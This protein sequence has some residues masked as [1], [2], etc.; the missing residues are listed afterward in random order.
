MRAFT[1]VP[2]GPLQIFL[3]SDDRWLLA[4][5]DEQTLCLCNAHN[6]Q[7]AA[8]F[9]ADGG[10]LDGAVSSDGRWKLVGEDA[11]TVQ[12]WD[13]TRRRKVRTFRQIAWDSARQLSARDGTWEVLPAKDYSIVIRDLV[14]EQVRQV[15]WGHTDKVNAVCASADGEWILSGGSDRTIRCWEVASGRCLRTFKAHA[16]AVRAVYLGSDGSWALSAGLDRTLKLWNLEL[17]HDTNRRFLSPTALCHITSS[18]EAS[19]TQ[20]EFIVLREK[21]Q[22]AVENGDFEECLNWSTGAGPARLRG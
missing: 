8:N 15:F 4:L 16:G 1:G 20:R 11:A 22:A 6:G 19:R 14:S 18:E 12:L 3:S 9:H 21:A 13:A 10:N 7:L 17:L 2:T 5:V